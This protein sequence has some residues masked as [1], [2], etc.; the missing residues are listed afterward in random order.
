MTS[1]DTLFIEE[2]LIN[3]LIEESF[4]TEENAVAVVHH[5]KIEPLIAIYKKSI[6][7][8]IKLKLDNNDLKV[9]NL[10]NEIGCKYIDIDNDEEFKN[11]NYKYEYDKLKSCF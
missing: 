9:M 10:L 3:K 7:D 2:V 8:I 6:I 11:I 5:E 1:V 4:N